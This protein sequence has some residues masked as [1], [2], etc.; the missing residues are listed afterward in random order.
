MV[1]LLLFN[2]AAFAQGDNGDVEMDCGTAENGNLDARRE[3]ALS[4]YE[5]NL[6]KNLGPL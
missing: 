3:P 1:R 6:C 5:V 2:C 4:H